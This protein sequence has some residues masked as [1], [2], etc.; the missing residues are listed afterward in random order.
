MAGGEADSTTGR[1]PSGLLASVLAVGAATGL[2]ALLKPHIPPVNL[3]PLYLL[4]ALPISV[5]WGTWNAVFAAVLGVA[6]YAFFFAPPIY[7]IKV[8]DWREA[9][10]LG[11]F[12][13]TAVVVARLADRLRQAALAAGRLSLEQAALRHVA[14][15]VAQSASARV[16]FEAVIARVGMLCDADV[17]RLERYE[18]DGTVSAIAAW[19]RV[20]AR[21][22][23]GRQFDLDGLSIARDVRRTCGP[24]RIDTFEASSGT[25]ADEARA[26]GIRSSVGCPVLV[27]G[28]LWGVIAASRTSDEPFPATTENQIASFTELVALAIENAEVQSELRASR[29]R[30]VTTADNTR[31]RIERDLHDGAQ[32]RIVSLMLQLREAQLSVRPDD[33]ELAAQLERVVSGL[34][35]AIDELREI[36]RGIHPS[37]L[38]DGGLARALRTLA[39]RAGLPVELSMHY[40]TRLPEAVEISAYYVVA[41]TLTN[42]AKHSRASAAAIDVEVVDDVLRITV[43]DDGRGGADFGHGTG[44]TGL[45]D[46]V[47]ALG[48]RL[49][50]DSPHGKGTTVDAALPLT[51]RDVAPEGGQSSGASRP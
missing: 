23:V 6:A 14:T 44:L 47:Q 18:P 10:A 41:E 15:L 19:S 16:V 42:A 21:L 50:V 48:G 36:A 8:A 24:S 1:V 2:I 26:I 31:R 27:S 51:D 12:L 20:S 43:R 49:L 35:D 46:R 37:I 34:D 17:A 30:I 5:I 13:V 4:G 25:I 29:A 32:Q 11:V 45:R 9:I 33:A 22:S 7:S 28:A 3:L 40:E 39:R 38:A